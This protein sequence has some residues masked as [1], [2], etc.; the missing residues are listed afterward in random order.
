MFVRAVFGVI[1]LLQY[2]D[3]DVGFQSADVRSVTA[4]EES[5]R[6]VSPGTG[7]ARGSSNTFAI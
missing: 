5:N 4:P 7:R 2:R 6:S 1:R 3:A